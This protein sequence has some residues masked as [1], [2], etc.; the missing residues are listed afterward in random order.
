MTFYILTTE[1]PTP[2]FVE[3]KAL[4]GTPGEYCE[5]FS[6]RRRS[7]SGNYPRRT[8]HSKERNEPPHAMEIVNSYGSK[9]QLTH[10]KAKSGSTF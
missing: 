2:P 3:N 9:H 8:R 5:P 4:M 7:R 1:I 6:T 10:R